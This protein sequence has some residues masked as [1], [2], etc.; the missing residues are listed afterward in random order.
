MTQQRK[1]EKKNCLFSAI[2][3]E[4][5]F[6]ITSPYDILDNNFRTSVD[7]MFTFVSAVCILYTKKALR[8]HK[9]EF[10]IGIVL[11]H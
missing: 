11:V 3:A 1:H 9:F 6:L 10:R 4:Q 2:G 7:L 5:P 8:I